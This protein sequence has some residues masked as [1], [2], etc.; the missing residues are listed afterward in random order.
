LA[1]QAAA[2]ADSVM[3]P[4]H[5]KVPVMSCSS[6]RAPLCPFQFHQSHHRY[7]HCHAMACDHWGALLDERAAAPDQVMS[8][9]HQATQAAVHHAS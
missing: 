7:R 4:D 5:T 1:E 8:K 9:V 6:L 2:E 3:V